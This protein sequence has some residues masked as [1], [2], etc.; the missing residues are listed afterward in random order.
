[1]PDE[2]PDPT[3]RLDSW[4]AIAAYLKRD[5]RTVRRWE[6]QLGLPVRRVPGGRGASVF[7]Y[8]AEIDAW[9][10]ETRPARR[11]DP[12][13]ETSLRPS[14]RVMTGAAMVL[15][16]AAAL[17]GWR[18]ADVG[19]SAPAIRV[20]IE[21]SGIVAV[22]SAGAVQWRYE[23][24]GERVEVPAAR[25]RPADI[26]TGPEPAVVAATSLQVS[27][28]TEAVQGGQLLS[29]TPRG[30]LGRTF[31]FDDRVVFG[32]ETY[33]GPW[34]ITDFRVDDRPGA[35]RI[36]AAAHH[37]QW[38][39]S[40]VVVLDQEFRRRGQFVNA[41]W[42]E[43]VHWM[44]PDRLLVAG[45]SEAL[46]GG[47]VALL[48]ANALDAQSP[49]AGD[50]FSCSTCG[51]GR[52]LRYIVMPR[53]EVNRVTASRFNRARLQLDAERVVIRT[54]EA[55]PTEQDVI[56]ALYEFTPG[57]ELVRASFSERYWEF[58]RRLEADGT[59]NHTRE[60]CPDRAGPREIHVW[61]PARGWTTARIR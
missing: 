47:M 8:G 40:I 14:R 23:F 17:F 2:Q 9:L 53:S 3:G 33:A 29:F 30:V 51:G 6:R 48:D 5:V 19:G 31:R 34:G 52:P 54:V 39:P 41:G 58:H 60:Q 21:Q 20:R 4:K 15:I 61:E 11:P 38:W 27:W 13:G 46:D 36:A 12:V 42:V 10:K 55:S 1:M 56:D 26:L 37:F 25:D 7:A 59:L 18:L 24:P 35:R 49:P 32:A 16:A 28:A 22:D 43:R 57:L 44:S 50:R 45:F